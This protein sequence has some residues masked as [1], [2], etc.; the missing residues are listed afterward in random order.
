MNT[1]VT[2][3]VAMMKT[4]IGAIAGGVVGGVVVLVAA[5]LIGVCVCRT[6]AH[7]QTAREDTTHELSTP[8]VGMNSEGI[9]DRIPTSATTDYEVGNIAATIVG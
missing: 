5:V 7:N 3:V 9:Y 1:A 2:S 6:R 4:S 8:A